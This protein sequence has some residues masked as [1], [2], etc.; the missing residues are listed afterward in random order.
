MRLNN[1]LGG[2]HSPTEFRK[3]KCESLG[4]ELGRKIPLGH[5]QPVKSIDRD[6]QAMHNNAHFMY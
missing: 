5:V 3:Q 1:A 6:Q 2:W 4:D